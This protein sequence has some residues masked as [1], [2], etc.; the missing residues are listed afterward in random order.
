MRNV[1]VISLACLILAGCSTKFAYNNFD[2]LV[3]WYLDDYIEL[4]DEQETFFDSNVEDWMA[5]H[6]SEEL[7]RYKNHLQ[8]IKTDVSNG[9][10]DRD[11]I[12]N[13][14]DQARAHYTRV[15]EKV[16]PAVADMA[17]EIS[18]EQVTYFF[19][20]LEKENKKQEKKMAKRLKDG[21]EK[22]LKRRI[23]DIT[24]D[25]ES[26]IGRLTAEQKDIIATY[27]PL[28][29][30]T[31][32]D[33]LAYRRNIQNEA[34]ILFAS[35]DTNPNFRQEVLYMIN[36]PDDYRSPEYVEYRDVNREQFLALLSE[37]APTL[38]EKQKT[39][40]IKEIDDIIDDLDDLMER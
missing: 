28:F 20:A 40:L 3:H 38:T 1:F 14:M 22:A 35:R 29:I 23:E 10:I 31:G 4:T 24:D 34:R 17:V 37:I 30:S 27:A 18:E 5:W 33:W 13:H 21:R 9:T 6:R 25:I 12:Q 36:N 32:Q 16:S 26:E 11:T 2:W 7:V 19:A 15:R 39:K 8:T